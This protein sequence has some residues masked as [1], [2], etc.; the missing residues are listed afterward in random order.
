[1]WPAYPS[2]ASVSSPAH[3]VL[4]PRAK[5]AVLRWIRPTEPAVSSRMERASGS[6]T[7]AFHGCRSAVG[8]DFR[9]RMP[10]P[11]PYRSSEPRVAQRAQ[12]R[13]FRQGAAV[14]TGAPADR[15]GWLVN[16][17]RGRGALGACENGPA[18]WWARMSMLDC[19]VWLTSSLTEGSVRAAGRSLPDMSLAFAL[20]AAINGSTGS[21]ATLSHGLSLPHQASPTSARRPR[22]FSS[23]IG[24]GARGPSQAQL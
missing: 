7:A 1:M 4:V 10:G 11:R 22:T 15:R 18:D 20:L 6:V 3:D 9:P 12:A 24:G 5:A 16:L 8:A 23:V 2:L 19:Q 13:W 17:P 14:S 21:C